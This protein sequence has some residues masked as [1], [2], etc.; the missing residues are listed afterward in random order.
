MCL[1][2]SCPFVPICV[3][4]CFAVI[5]FGFLIY[6][7]VYLRSS[8]VTLAGSFLNRGWTQMKVNAHSALSLIHFIVRWLWYSYITNMAGEINWKVRYGAGM[9]RKALLA[10][11]VEPL[12]MRKPV[13]WENIENDPFPMPEKRRRGI[14]QTRKAGHDWFM[15]KSWKRTWQSCSGRRTKNNGSGG[16]NWTPDTADMSRML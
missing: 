2:Y 16:G 1:N 4:S 9:R 14:I 11:L 15:G 7:C 5:F 6:I 10:S 13:G 12:S 8:A 3:L